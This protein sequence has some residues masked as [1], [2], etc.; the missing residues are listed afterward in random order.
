MRYMTVGL[1]KTVSL[2]LLPIDD[3]SERV[4][5]GSGLRMYTEEGKKPSIRKEDGYHV[6]CD[7]TGENV[8]ICIEGPLY[9]KQ[10][11]ELPLGKT[12]GIYQVRVLPNTSYPIPSGATC[13]RGTLQPGSRIRIFFPEQKKNYKLLYD[14]NP[15]KEGERL[16]LFSPEKVKL[17][18]KT[19]CIRNQ[20][21]EEFFRVKSQTDGICELEEALQKSYKKIGTGVYPVYEACAGEDGSFYLPIR[22]IPVESG[23]CVVRIAGKDG[24]KEQC[25]QLI[26]TAGK[27]NRIMENGIMDENRME[28]Y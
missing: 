1:K 27:E 28:E 5:T 6:F 4:I 13:V 12:P 8:R 17:E 18:G 21:T 25:R 22:S 23:S 14:Y 20:D 26:L 15:E 24:Q 3:F 19:L 16:A 11:L 10:T 2:V 9:Q 7:L